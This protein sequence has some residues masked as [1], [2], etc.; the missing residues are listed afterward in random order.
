MADSVAAAV[1][2]AVQDEMAVFDARLRK[3]ELILESAALRAAPAEIGEPPHRGS[4]EARL[5]A[6]P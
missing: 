5:D 6:K 2:A 1:R 3:I 4:E